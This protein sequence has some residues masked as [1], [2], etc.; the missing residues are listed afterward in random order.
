MPQIEA[1]AKRHGIVSLLTTSSKRAVFLSIVDAARALRT[2]R[3]DLCCELDVFGQVVST[4]LRNEYGEIVPT[5]DLDAVLD[6]LRPRRFYGRVEGYRGPRTG[7]V[8]SVHRL[9]GGCYWRHPKT[10]NERRL[11]GLVLTEDGEPPIRPLRTGY[12]LPS[13]HDD[14]FRDLSRNWKR[15]RKTQWGTCLK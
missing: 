7:A 12:H 8:P 4:N 1:I 11:C 3:I 14:M 10:Q 9:R 6:Y 5:A 13:A 2:C 15:Y